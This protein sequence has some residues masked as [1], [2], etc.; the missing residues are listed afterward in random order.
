MQLERDGLITHLSFLEHSPL[1]NK[2]I[3]RRKVDVKPQHVPEVG[4]DLGEWH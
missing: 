1:E 4:D 3:L 2:D